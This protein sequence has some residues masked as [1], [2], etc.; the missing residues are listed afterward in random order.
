L[1]TAPTLFTSFLGW[2]YAGGNFNN[3]DVAAVGNNYEFALIQINEGNEPYDVQN[4]NYTMKP[5][6]VSDAVS[7]NLSVAC[8]LAKII[9]NYGILQTSPGI[10]AAMYRQSLPLAQAD[11][12]VNATLGNFTLGGTT[13]TMAFTQGSALVV[14]GGTAP[15][16]NG[17]VGNYLAVPNDMVSSPTTANVDVYRIIAVSAGVSITLDRPF[18]E[19]TTTMTQAQAQGTLLKT[20]TAVQNVGLKFTA[21]NAGEVW[22]MA[23]RDE[24]LYA[25]N[26]AGT[27]I[28]GSGTAIQVQQLELEGSTF[29]GDS[30][31]NTAF[32]A[33]FGLQDYFV[34]L[35]DTYDY[36]FLD[37]SRTFPTLDDPQQSGSHKGGIVICC[38]KSA[39]NTL[40][41]LTTIFGV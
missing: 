21:I 1:Y 36:Y 40:S 29:Q 22:R 12:V 41:Q 8:A 7:P 39:G 20:V 2:N 9:N 10:A 3:P 23:Q 35:T 14:L 13:P 34:L 18:K 5:Q 27:F 28:N 16:F 33:N 26:T 32:A 24:L 15:V 19:A 4:F 38:P 30:A 37:Y 17:A 25:D 31:K 6:D 11:V